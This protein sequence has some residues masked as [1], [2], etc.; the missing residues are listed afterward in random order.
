MSEPFVGE[1][2]MFPYTFTPYGWLRCAGQAVPVNQYQVLFAVIGVTYG[3]DGVN[4]FKVPNLTDQAVY[5]AG[6]GPGLTP[7][8]LGKSAGAAGVALTASQ[9]PAHTHTLNTC[10]MTGT[11]TSPANQYLGH[12]AANLIYKESPDAPSMVAMAATSLTGAGSGLPHE[13]RQ[14][15]LAVPFCIA[16]EGVFPSRN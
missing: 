15:A 12:Y 1:V 5:G 10:S 8:L 13:N 4:T 9:V 14:P 2:R 3:G 7:R 11:S 16:A 6:N